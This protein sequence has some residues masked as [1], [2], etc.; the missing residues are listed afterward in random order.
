MKL[1]VE[2]REAAAAWFAVQR[3]AVM[4]I[5]ER[6]A[7]DGWRVDP[8]NLAALNAMHELWGEMAA[9]KAVRPV[10]HTRSLQRRR[11]AVGAAA[12]SQACSRSP[13]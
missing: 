8:Q 11:I 12:G 7:F 6:E 2:R 4:S 9:L 1:S 13:P 10:L 5:E 3:R